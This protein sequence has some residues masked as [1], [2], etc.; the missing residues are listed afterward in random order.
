MFRNA[1]GR[2]C[3]ASVLGGMAFVALIGLLPGGCSCGKTASEA[4]A[5]SL[6]VGEPKYAQMV[7]AF[8]TGAIAL[9]VGS[10]SAPNMVA[11]ESARKATQ[12]EPGEP[13]AWANLGLALMRAGDTP[14]AAAALDRAHKLKSDN[15]RIETLYAAL[16]SRRGNTAQALERL[17]QAV[18]LDPSNLKARFALVQQLEQQ[19]DGAEEARSHLQQIV[20]ARP[21][22]LFALLN[23]ARDAAQSG[24]SALLRQMVARIRQHVDVFPPDARARFGELQKLAAGAD[25]R[26]AA[27]SVSILQNQIVQTLAYR[28]DLSVVRTNDTDFGEPLEQFLVLPSPSPTPAPPDTAL[29]FAAQP[30]SSTAGGPWSAA[31]VLALTPEVI[32][33]EAHKFQNGRTRVVQTPEGPPFTLL[34]NGKRLQLLSAEG[35]SIVLPFPGGAKTTPPAPE[36]VLALDFSYDFRLDL[37]LAGAGGVRLFQQ[38]EQNTFTDVTGRSGLP[39]SVTNAAYLGA[40]AADIESDGDLDIVLAAVKGPPVVLR[41]NGDGT[42]TSIQPFAGVTEARAF[43]WADLDGDGDV[44]AAFLD[45]QGRL[46][47]F[48]NQ[49]AGHFRRWKMTT[50][51]GKLTALSVCDVTGR[52]VMDLVVLRADGVIAR[53]FREPNDDRWQTREIARWPEAPRDGT[54]RLTWADLDNNGAQDLIASG[55]SGTRIWLGGAKG[56]LIPLTAPIAERVVAVGPTPDNG[57]LDLLGI[58]SRGQP[59]RLVNQGRKPYHWQIVKGRADYTAPPYHIGDGRINSFGVGGEVEVRAG[60]LYQKQPITGPSLH[61]G[62]G[63]NP[64]ADAIRVL[65]PSGPAAVKFAEKSDAVVTALQALGTSCPWLFAFDGKGMKLVTDCIWRS[66]L[67]LKINA[68]ATAGIVQTEDWVKIRGDQLV[69]QD[70]CYD[71]RICAELWETHYF[72]YLALMIVDHPAGTDIFVDERF[73]IPPPALKVYATTPPRPV[74][75]AVD[76]LGQDVTSTLRERDGKYLGSFGRGQYQG[77]TRDHYVELELPAEAPATGPLY[78]VATGWIRPTT[79]SINVAISQGHH[80]PPT[81]LSLEIPDGKGGWRVARPGLGFPE[82]KIK[83]VLLD[84]TGLFPTTAPQ[85]GPRR[86]RL[87]TNLEIYWDC[88]RWA[89]GLPQ[90]P[91]KTQRLATGSA[92]LRYRGFSVTHQDDPFAPDIP[93]YDEI[94]TTSQRWRAM[95]GCYT[96]YGEVGPLLA[97]VDDRYVITGPGD[98]LALRFPAQAPPPTGWTRDYV[99]IGDG[100]VKDDDYNTTFAQTVLPLPAHDIKG[101]RT[102]PGR[103]EDDPVYKRHA[104]DWQDY[105]TR[106][107]ESSAFRNAMRLHLPTAPSTAAH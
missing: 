51:P 89:A 57:R 84:L 100:W 66:P 73:A 50:E 86:V 45:S 64:Q 107:V 22:N 68:Q 21:N 3:R 65:W 103:L 25:V 56:E 105:H 42:W 58:S 36:G 80:P 76:D 83:T 93:I 99:L 46:S 27:T 90:T 85:N 18:K 92:D 91:L 88:I 10:S 32:A 44:D 77:V 29:T 106:Y 60:L 43:A 71:L 94:A 95:E 53:I 35:R 9:A 34:A 67:G 79:S 69:P 72:D 102:P 13:A 37:A 38:G 52:G 87:R 16:E 15:S 78:L 11:V 81:G 24:N 59:V 97:K 20:D 48:E 98:E 101:Y 14:G 82:G 30:L 26:P 96:R 49:L 8:H 31:R 4:T 33:D 7:S 104:Q 75:R 1:S 55:S 6:R 23:L 5:P 62:L 74:A 19:P 17:R 70:G 39:A 61:F 47:L 40:W 12:L 2:F 63:D 28:Q 54:A 41:N